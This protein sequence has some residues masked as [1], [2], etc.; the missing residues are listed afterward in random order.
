MTKMSKYKLTTE[1][2]LKS[3][4][5]SVGWF[6]HKR[7]LIAKSFTATDYFVLSEE[8]EEVSFIQ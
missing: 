4:G 2:I 6:Y 5:D 1:V 3:F 8:S 7:P